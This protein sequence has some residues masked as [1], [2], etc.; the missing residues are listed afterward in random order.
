MSWFPHRNRI[1]RSHKKLLVRCSLV[2][3]F[4]IIGLILFILVFKYYSGSKKK[5]ALENCHIKFWDPPLSPG[6]ATVGMTPVRKS[7]SNCGQKS[8]L[9]RLFVA[10]F[11]LKTF[12]AEHAD[13]AKRNEI[14][15]EREEQKIMRN[16]FKKKRTIEW[17]FPT[18]RAIW[19]CCVLSYERGKPVAE[20]LAFFEYLFIIII[21]KAIRLKRK[22]VR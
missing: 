16:L 18:F 21:F 17:Y 12:M 1:E 5:S 3:Q 4:L 7:W 11:R 13:E 19:I 8:F 15:K 2:S 10:I 6:I 14:R 9:A 22:C 20:S